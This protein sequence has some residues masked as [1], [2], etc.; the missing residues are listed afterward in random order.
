MTGRV[1][2]MVQDRAAART[3]GEGGFTLIELLMSIVIIGL[4]VLVILAFA[5]STMITQA[6][7]RHL[8]SQTSNLA[9]LDTSLLRDVV[10]SQFAIAR[11]S[12]N[13]DVVDCENYR[14][15]RGDTVLATVSSA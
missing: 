14:G 15:A 7:S 2:R 4:I 6:Q 1:A 12:S 3:R 5:T 10:S 9:L 13:N 8:A 11:P